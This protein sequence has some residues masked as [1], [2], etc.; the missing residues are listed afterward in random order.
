MLIKPRLRRVAVA[1]AAIGLTALATACMPADGTPQTLTLAGSDTTQDVMNQ[2]AARW[3]ADTETNTDPDTAVNILAIQNTALTVPGDGDC[4]SI[5]YKTNPGAGQVAPPNG[6][7]AGRD[8]LAASVNNGNGCVDVARSSATPRAVPPDNSTFEYYAFGLDAVAWASASAE[9]PSNITLDNLRKIFNCTFT[10]WNQVGGTA[11]A[12][13]R[14]WPQ[15]GSGTRAFFQSEVLGFDPTTVSGGSCPAVTLTEE[16]TG[17]TIA[18]NGDTA[19]AIVPYAGSKWIAQA[20]GK[21]PD[22]RGG[23]TIRNLNGKNVIR[24]NGT[25]WEPNSAATGGPV[26]ESNVALVDPTPAYPGIRYVFNVID[27]TGV[28]YSQAKRFIGFENIDKGAKS[29]LCKGSEATTLK[30]FGF[31]VLTATV[32]PNNVIGSTCRLFAP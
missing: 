5:T 12:I 17:A 15:A 23:Q 9:A 13:K 1:V 19:T 7:S 6:S 30:D 26:D 16:N 14:Y 4:G 18:A 25:K 27:S 22:T 31:G 32:A 24:L 10:N 11:G 2:I 21:S 20:N 29:P 28:T 3:N 8:A